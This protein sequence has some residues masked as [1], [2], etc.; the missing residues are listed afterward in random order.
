[1]FFKIFVPACRRGE[2]SGAE[3]AGADESSWTGSHFSNIFVRKH[4]QP[5]E[6]FTLFKYFVRK[7]FQPMERFTLFKYFC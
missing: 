7:H 2:T 5:I 3:E 1:M 4:F 6:R